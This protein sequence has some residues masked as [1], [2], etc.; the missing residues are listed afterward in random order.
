MYVYTEVSD[1]DMNRK[2]KTILSGIY[3]KSVNLTYTSYLPG[4][5]VVAGVYSSFKVISWRTYDRLQVRNQI[6]ALSILVIEPKRLKCW[7]EIPL[8]NLLLWQV[9]E[10]TNYSTYI[11][12]TYEMVQAKIK[13]EGIVEILPS[14]QYPRNDLVRFPSSV[15][16]GIQ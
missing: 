12:S 2:K 11:A 14:R 9:A 16:L 15:V 4:A 6:K 7:L 3:T 10:T 1:A 5:A 8:L 13:A